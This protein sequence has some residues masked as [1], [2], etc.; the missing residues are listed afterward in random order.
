MDEKI[1]E[2]FTVTSDKVMIVKPSKYVEVRIHDDY[3]ENGVSTVIGDCVETFAFLD[4]FAWDEYSE[5]L[6]DSDATKIALRMPMVVNTKPTRIEHDSK[7]SLTILEYHGGDAFI[8]STLIPKNSSVVIKY[9]KLILSGK[10]PDD[11]PYNEIVNYLENCCDINGV[12]M[13]VNSIFLDLIVM[14]VSRDPSNLTRQFREA[15][16]DNHKISMLSRKLV[17]MDVIPSLSSQFSAITSGNPKY[18]ITSSIGAVRSGDMVV[19]ESDI[20][21]AIK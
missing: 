1:K 6:K 15:L 20:E 18:G 21:N 14:V 11:I 12:D 19:V 9:I 13:K 7:K 3:F 2:F 8:V 5:N 10:I 16:K 4:I 17:N